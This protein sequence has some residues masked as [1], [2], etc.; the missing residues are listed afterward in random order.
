MVRL[1][2]NILSVFILTSSTYSFGQNNFNGRFVG[3]M[4]ISEWTDEN[5]KKR[6]YGDDFEEKAEW[7]HECDLTIKGDSVWF[8][9]NPISIRNGQKFYSASDGAFYYYSGKLT[10]YKGKSF[11]S[12]TLINCDYCPRLN[13]FTPPK[14]INDTLSSNIDTTNIVANDTPEAKSEIVEEDYSPTIKYKTYLIELT[15]DN[16]IL[17]D[18]KILFKRQKKRK[19]Y[20]SQH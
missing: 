9:K 19:H 6:Y 15:N 13:K 12:L 4:R 17:L 20:Y 8:E 5:G 11:I 2:L 18:K 7:Y 3:R 14:I 10:T 16:N 1:L